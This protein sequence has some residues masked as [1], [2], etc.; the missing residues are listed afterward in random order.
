MVMCF[1]FYE[2]LIKSEVFL[3]ISLEWLNNALFGRKIAVGL[4]F[5]LFR[6]A[7]S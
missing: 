6:H 3:S 2:N 4:G 1:V 7:L 5:G